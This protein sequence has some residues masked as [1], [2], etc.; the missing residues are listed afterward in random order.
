MAKKMWS[1]ASAVVILTSLVVACSSGDTGTPPGATT[2]PASSTPAGAPSSVSPNTESSSSPPTAGSSGG[3]T[4]STTARSIPDN[5]DPNAS[6]VLMFPTAPGPFDPVAGV[7]TGTDQTYY[8]PVLERLTTLNSDLTLAPQ[9]ATAWKA[10][11][12]GLSWTFT[13]RDGVKFQDGTPFNADAVVKNIQRIQ[14]AKTSVAA[15]QIS[16]VTG[17]TADSDTQVTFTLSKP[18]PIF[19]K[20]LALFPEAGSIISPASFN[21]PDVGTK[22]VGTG[23]YSVSASSDTDVTYEKV[24]DYWDPSVVATTPAK[25]TIRAFPDPVAAA[26]ALQSGQVDSMTINLMTDDLINLGKSDKYD[27]QLYDATSRQAIFATNTNKKPFSDVRVRQA[28]SLALNREEITAGAFAGNCTPTIQPFGSGL[29]GHD[30]SLKADNYQNQDQ[31]RS[32]LAAAGASNI[33]VK[34]LFGEGFEPLATIIQAELAEVG[35]NITWAA[36]PTGQWL[37]MWRQGDYDVTFFVPG[38]LPDEQLVLEQY[39]TG[40][41]FVGTPPADLAALVADAAG[42]PLDSPERQAGFQEISKYIAANPTNIPICFSPPATLHSTRLGGFADMAYPQ[43]QQ[44]YDVS[45]LF[46]TKS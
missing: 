12:D 36:V 17:V 20:R 45:K 8:S 26:N 2:A 5:V 16:I 41:N 42:R 19:P 38:P 30:D 18:D 10:G 37:A 21:S 28:I 7:S 31:A 25:I 4:V 14:A 40:L 11:A 29:P 23:P 46:T 6:V 35:I 34:G 13:L 27:M 1:A 44:T 22:P 9:L 15:S 43:I 39:Y 33:N 32:L 24:A 3:S